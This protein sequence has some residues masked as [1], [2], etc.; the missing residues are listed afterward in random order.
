M[1]VKYFD[2]GPVYKCP[3]CG[4]ISDLNGC[5]V[6]GADDGWLFCNN[7]HEQFDAEKSQITERQYTEHIEAEVE[8]VKAELR[9]LAR[10][11]CDVPVFYNPLNLFKAKQL[12]D[13]I[14][15]AEG[16]E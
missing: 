8:K 9:V 14:L 7:C 6:L 11:A 4:E 2:E 16:K 12:R 1:K 3:H 15:E 13:R 5:D 10:L